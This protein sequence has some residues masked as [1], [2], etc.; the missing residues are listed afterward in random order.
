MVNNRLWKAWAAIVFG[1]IYSLSEHEVYVQ[2]CA[3]MCL[4]ES[5]TGDACDEMCTLTKKVPI[6]LEKKSK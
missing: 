6:I 5:A 1:Y 4:D 3:R 2:G